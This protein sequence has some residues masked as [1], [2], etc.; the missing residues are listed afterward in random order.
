MNLGSELAYGAT[1]REQKRAASKLQAETRG[2]LVVYL[3]SQM[4]IRTLLYVMPLAFYS[5]V[6][7]SYCL[8]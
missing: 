3:F 8:T 6:I 5:I 2:M 4:I 1:E 7:Y